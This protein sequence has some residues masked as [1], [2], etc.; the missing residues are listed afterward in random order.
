MDAILQK[1]MVLMA[2]NTTVTSI[3]QV[4]RNHTL[5]I[6]AK[7]VIFLHNLVI[8]ILIIGAF[9]TTRKCIRAHLLLTAGVFVMWFCLDGCILTFFEKELI[10]YS[11]SEKEALHGTYEY[12]AAHQLGV[13]LPLILYDFYKLLV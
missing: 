2:V 1:V 13:T 5:G 12:G 6:D 10:Q 9:L 4:H 8:M 3:H 11:P 7:L